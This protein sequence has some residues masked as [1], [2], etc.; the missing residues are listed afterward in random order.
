MVSDGLC[1]TWPSRSHSQLAP[2]GECIYAALYAASRA[3][4]SS[5]VHGGGSGSAVGVLVE[6]SECAVARVV[7]L[8]SIKTFSQSASLE[9]SAVHGTASQPTDSPAST[10]IVNIIIAPTAPRSVAIVWRVWLVCG[11]NLDFERGSSQRSCWV[12]AVFCFLFV[13]WW[14]RRVN[15]VE[16]LY[17]LFGGDH[18][19]YSLGPQGS[20][21]DY[22]PKCGY[23]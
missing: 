23:R 14:P 17:N 3:P 4:W 10:T 2:Y 21:V 5:M 8:H 7:W 16:R 12:F 13:C 1:T 18:R 19:R 22:S 6:C 11:W 9:C 15:V 20:A